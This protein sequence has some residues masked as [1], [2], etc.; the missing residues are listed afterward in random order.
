MIPNATNVKIGQNVEVVTTRQQPTRTYRIDFSAG[1]VRG[2]TDETEAMKQAIVKI[3]DTERFDHLIYSWNYGTELNAVVGKSFQVLSSEIKRVIREA[4][5]ADSRIEDVT[6]F[7]I[8][9]ID[10]RTV[11]VS[12]LASTVWGGIPIERK[13][14]IGV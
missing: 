5:L 3:I 11:S 10:K 13:V 14:T 4:L 8:I 6:D 12:F 2:I 7:S 1:R 9:Q